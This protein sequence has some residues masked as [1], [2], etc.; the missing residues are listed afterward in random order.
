MIIPLILSAFT[1]LWNPIG[2]PTL[3]VDEGHYMRRA[4]QILRGL[5]PQEPTSSYVFAYDHPYFGQLFLAGALKIIGY[6]DSLSPKSGDIHSI[7]MLYIAPRIL[8]GLLAI[9][10]TLLIYKISE[11]RYNRNIAFIASI[12]FAVMPFGWMTRG[13][14]LDSILLPLLLSSI[15]FAL[16]T[17]K[18]VR[19]ENHAKSNN[20]M[21]LMSGIFLGLAIFTKAPII[22]MIPLLVIIILKNNKHDF[23]KVAILW[24]MPVILI[25]MLWPLYAV[26]T[27]QFGEWL[28]GV[29][30]QF[31]RQ[32]EKSNLF[33]SIILISKIDVVMLVI[34][35][36]GFVYTQ[37]KRDYFLML[38]AIPYL[39]FLYLI[40]WVTHFHWI[41]LLPVMCISGAILFEDISGRFRNKK[42][43]NVTRATIILAIG[44][45]G[46]ATTISLITLN[47]NSSYLEVYAFMERELEDNAES[48][49]NK[50]DND[51][52]NL[53]GSQR[54]KALTWIPQ[55]VHD[56]NFYFRDIN[57]PWDNFTAPI[58]VN[59]NVLL[60]VDSNVRPKLVSYPNG[61]EK[62]T[63]IGD[64]YYGTH[65]IA[66]FINRKYATYDFLNTVANHGLG[67]FIEV[68]SNY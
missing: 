39:I 14:F 17:K 4:M 7:E 6:P 29:L 58:D 54:I 44:I 21:I 56:I 24:L 36:A 12:L 38:W 60:V 11:R 52:L 43:A 64:I 26:G 50:H 66:T 53:I 35:V 61:T 65:T 46:L 34:G 8:M 32:T 47:L 2:F 33:Q 45:F 27:G 55:Y 1:H 42:V 10:D 67:P 23:R 48:H 49:N 15:L 62:Y 18:I 9:I 59:S 51:T 3:H 68:R 20:I 31:E 19:T 25:P 37:V 63:R 5:G 40:G 57:N 30:Y 16:Q 41:V 22:T 13:I 28:N